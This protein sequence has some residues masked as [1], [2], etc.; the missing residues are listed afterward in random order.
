MGTEIERKFLVEDPS[1]VDG[2]LGTVIRQGYLSRV[3]E[4]TVR[5]RRMGD[6]A[7]VTIKGAN[8]G[9]RRSEWEYEIPAADADELLLLC[10]GPVLDKTRYVIEVAGR[11]WE[12]DVF[13]GANA[14]L[15]IAEVELDDETA[16]V[17][18]P[19]WAGLEVTDDPRYYNSNLSKT[20]VGG[21][22]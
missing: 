22:A 21:G 5:V 15:V 12:V 11:D 6:R 16:V 3:K 13:A 17:E 9:P 14:G 1:V 10:E 7:F 8:V 20:P 18:L 2:R 4:R 19:A